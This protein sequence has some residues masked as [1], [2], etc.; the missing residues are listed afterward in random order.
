MVFT[1][2]D[3]FWGQPV[4]LQTPP[5]LEDFKNL[6]DEEG[7]EDLGPMMDKAWPAKPTVMSCG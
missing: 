1:N 7:E 4:F 6:K 2:P 3:E 5:Q